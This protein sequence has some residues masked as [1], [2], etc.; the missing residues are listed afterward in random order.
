MFKCQFVIRLQHLH[1]RPP[2]LFSEKVD[3]STPID[4]RPPKVFSEKVD[5]STPIDTYAL[6]VLK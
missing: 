6:F 3:L 2:K 1:M 5:L 4:M